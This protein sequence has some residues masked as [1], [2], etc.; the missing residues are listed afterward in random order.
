[1]KYRKRVCMECEMFETLFTVHVSSS[2]ARE[3][4]GDRERERER[5]GEGEGGR[6]RYGERAPAE[7]T[8]MYM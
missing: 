7:T 6:G 5:K 8:I 3:R 1:M 2:D 4:E